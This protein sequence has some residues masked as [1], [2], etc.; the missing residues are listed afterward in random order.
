[1]L[2]VPA[3]RLAVPVPGDMLRSKGLLEGPGTEG[4]EGWRDGMGRVGSGVEDV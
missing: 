1:V 2:H 4:H 3:T